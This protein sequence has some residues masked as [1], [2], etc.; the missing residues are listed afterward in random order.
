LGWGCAGPNPPRQ[1]EP[2]PW[3]D[4]THDLRQRGYLSAGTRRR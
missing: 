1:L 2:L 4:S 3:R